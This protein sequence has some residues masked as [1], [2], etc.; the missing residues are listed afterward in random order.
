M[1][2]K[3]TTHIG[4]EECLHLMHQ[5]S[6]RGQKN[7]AFLRLFK[8]FELPTICHVL[9][10]LFIAYLEVKQFSLPIRPF[11]RKATENQLVFKFNSSEQNGGLV[12][13]AKFIQ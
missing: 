5:K 8:N 2:E 13:I 12:L 4:M 7:V 10:F 11:F 3:L 6:Q 9:L 1:P